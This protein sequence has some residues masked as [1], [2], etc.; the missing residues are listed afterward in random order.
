MLV[1][2]WG[3][4][5]KRRQKQFYLIIVLMV[6]ASFAE[7]ISLGIV[8]PFLGVLAMPEQVYQHQFIQPIVQQLNITSAE[9]LLFPITILFILS[10]LFAGVVR[11]T[12]LYTMTRISFAT[13]A[14][15]SLEIY[16]RTLYQEYAVHISR[17]SSVVINGILTK[18]STVINGVINPVLTLTSSVIL[19]IA[20]MVAL[21]IIDS[22]V[23]IIVSSGFG[24]IYSS[25][26]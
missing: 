5:S 1:E 24:V 10:V 6:V 13:G 23:A 9:Q 17:N 21:F 14:D 2:L 8:I 19:I 11:L 18:T 20:V 16:K 26:I 25:V 15:L 3:Y 12:L 4:I 7:V 22:T